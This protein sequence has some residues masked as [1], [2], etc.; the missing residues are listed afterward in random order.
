MDSVI[1][2]IVFGARVVIVVVSGCSWRCV[3]LFGTHSSLV[4]SSP[5]VMDTTAASSSYSAQ[6]SSSSTCAFSLTDCPG[7]DVATL[8]MYVFYRVF[9]LLKPRRGEMGE[10]GLITL[11][12]V[13]W[14]FKCADFYYISVLK[15]ERERG[16]KGR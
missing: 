5:V 14:R 2:V 12:V 13:E 4:L 10:V 1:V 6:S 16:G 3:A 8:C 7:L 11:L 9:M 15:R